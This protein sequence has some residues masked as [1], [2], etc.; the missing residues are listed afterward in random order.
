MINLKTTPYCILFL[1]LS[2]FATA[3]EK[4]EFKLS[5]YTPPDYVYKSLEFSYDLS[6]S[7]NHSSTYM[8]D[9]L[10]SKNIIN[11][12]STSI[13]PVYYRYSNRSNYQGS[14]RLQ[15]YSGISINKDDPYYSSHSTD[16]KHLQS[17]SAVKIY[18]DGENRF[19]FAKKNYLE[20]DPAIRLITQNTK[21]T[22]KTFDNDVLTEQITTN[23]RRPEVYISAPLLFGSGRIDNIMDARHAVYI[24]DDLEK[25]GRLS[26]DYNDEDIK[27]LATG[28]TNLK[29]KRF[30]DSRLRKIK[31]LVALD[32]LLQTTGFKGEND[33]LF[34]ATLN[35]SWSYP[36]VSYRYS[37]SRIYGGID[38]EYQLNY[39]RTSVDFKFT[40]DENSKSWEHTSVEYLGIKAGFLRERPISLQWQSTIDVSA[41]YGIEQDIRK[42]KMI[43]PE[44]GDPRE[45]KSTQPRGIV[46][47]SYAAGFYPNSRTT[48][49]AGILADLLYYGKGKTRPYGIEESDL[50]PSYYLNIGPQANAFIYISPQISISF[51]AS[52]VYNRHWQKNPFENADNVKSDTWNLY[53]T[54]YLKYSLF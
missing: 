47:V 4:E 27:S 22:D 44:P 3:Q 51:N 17:G 34:F 35:D 32:S 36:G 9:S 23:I 30:F 38:P 54:S 49:N 1:T 52:L 8:G 46:S 41:G 13:S 10:A 45:W 25:A 6:G 48:L 2:L 5:S 15:L 53:L 18:Y 20:F 43:L 24:L 50:Q 21:Y 11:Y 7:A 37:G 33:A 26:R 19:Y 42:E 31:E 29:N 12:F 40:P 14:N 39:T 16:N 28:I